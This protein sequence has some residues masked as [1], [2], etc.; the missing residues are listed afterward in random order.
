MSKRKKVPREHQLDLSDLKFYYGIPHCHTS[1]STGKGNPIEVLDHAK[2][3][4]L[5]FIILSDHN[6]YL[7]DSIKDREGE[8]SKWHILQ[9]SINRFNKKH[10]DFI[11][12]HGFEA[13]STLL[14]DLNIINSKSY[15]NGTVTNIN[16]LILWLMQDNSAFICIN[17]PMK[18]M[19]DIEYSPLLSKFIRCIEIGNS[20]QMNKHSKYEKYYYTFLDKGFDI[21]AISS[22]DNN[23][24]NFGELEN[25]TCAISNR[26]DKQSII[27][28]FK[29]K[30][31]FST[32][33]KTL[34]LFF[35]INSTFMGGEIPTSDT[36]D[37]YIYAEDSNKKINK[38]QIITN[39]G[40]II[41]EIS[42]I[43]LY[44]I[45]YIFKKDGDPKEDWYAIKVIL[46]DKRVAI[47]SPI[48]VRDIEED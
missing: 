12:F 20:C 10:E 31:T 9:K 44:R 34:K 46:N 47:T 8:I 22:Q 45:K 5:H 33:S 41:K 14:G 23:K 11:G 36:L 27:N 19:E 17:H 39:G 3:S 32:E 7:S 48:M 38:I 4:G 13:H 16:A 26:F 1:L 15:F 29:N 42:D 6:E 21:S 43:N 35:T 40:E 28:A 2:K 30:H 24:L 25:L 18:S 37:F